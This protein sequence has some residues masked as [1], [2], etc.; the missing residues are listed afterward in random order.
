MFAKNRWG[1]KGVDCA[2][3]AGL[4]YKY[5][6]KITSDYIRRLCSII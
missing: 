1:A 2:S 3:V 6:M 4:D 5:G